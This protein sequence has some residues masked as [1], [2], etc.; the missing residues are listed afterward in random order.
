M[1]SSIQPLNL[2]SKNVK[3][4]RVLLVQSTLIYSRRRVKL[5]VHGSTYVLL[6][7]YSI[8]MDGIII[9]NHMFLTQKID[10]ISR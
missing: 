8:L 3:A 7:Y 1:C 6:K 2:P 10:S 5:N 4:Q 9:V